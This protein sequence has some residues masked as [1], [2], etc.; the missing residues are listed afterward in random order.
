MTETR[1]SQSGTAPPSGKSRLRVENAP[2]NLVN[3][4]EYP[5]PNSVRRDRVRSMHNAPD[6][7]RMADKQSEAEKAQA[8]KEYQEAQDAAIQ[9]MAKL[10]AVRLARD[11]AATPTLTKGKKPVPK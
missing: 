10:R 11:A 2:K 5:G 9:R 4:R 3:R 7:V 1:R 6:E 8:R